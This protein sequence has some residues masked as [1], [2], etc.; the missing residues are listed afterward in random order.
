M[1]LKSVMK[2]VMKSFKERTV[3]RTPQ[4]AVREHVYLL[5]DLINSYSKV[6]T[7]VS[8]PR[9]LQAMCIQDYLLN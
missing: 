7:S 5:N 3:E 6:R 9:V 8:A 1:K 4:T 2:S